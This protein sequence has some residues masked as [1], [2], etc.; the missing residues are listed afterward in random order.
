MN[1]TKVFKP[2][3]SVQAYF[4]MT[5]PSL[6]YYNQTSIF[7]YMYIMFQRFLYFAIKSLKNHGPCHYHIIEFHI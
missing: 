2:I 3:I 6:Y 1:S 5:K 4:K 7:I